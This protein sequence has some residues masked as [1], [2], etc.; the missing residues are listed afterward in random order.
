MNELPELPP[1]YFFRIYE[2]YF[3]GPTVVVQLRRR[4]KFGPLRWSLQV[5]KNWSTREIMKVS[6]DRE[7][8][9]AIAR[10]QAAELWASKRP[11]ELGDLGGDSDG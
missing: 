7:V 4:F 1:G 9:L 8:A 10:N 11:V 6:T 2:G 3:F 5:I